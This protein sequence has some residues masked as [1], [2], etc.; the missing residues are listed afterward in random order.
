M[1]YPTKYHILLLNSF[2]SDR[3]VIL[4]LLSG[5]LTS[6]WAPFQLVDDEK[7]R[8][9]QRFVVSLPSLGRNTRLMVVF[10][11]IL[12]SP[13]P[14]PLGNMRGTVPAHCHGHWFDHLFRCI[15]WLFYVCLLPWRPLGWYEARSCPMP[16]SSNF[17]SS[18]GHAALGDAIC[19]APLHCRGHQN[20]R[21]TRCIYSSLSILSSTRTVA[22][23][24]L[25]VN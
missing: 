5:T 13:K 18:P 2:L 4:L 7:S 19:I 15:W 1:W 16:A 21:R 23:D 9:K 17:R 8:K 11:G 24:H 6:S 12:Q 20:S 14:P 3:Y 25:M 10:S 22:N